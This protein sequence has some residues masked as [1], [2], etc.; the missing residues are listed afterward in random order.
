MT[1]QSHNVMTCESRCHVIGLFCVDCFIF[2]SSCTLCVALLGFVSSLACCVIVIIFIGY[3]AGLSLHL[4]WTTILVTWLPAYCLFVY[5]D[6][7]GNHFK[8][9]CLM[10]LIAVTFMKHQF[11]TFIVFV[12]Y[13]HARLPVAL[14]CDMLVTSGTWPD[15]QV[16]LP[17]SMFMCNGTQSLEIR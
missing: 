17:D 3:F 14:F 10:T 7:C 4:A 13:W 16:C 12:L 8:H 2:T 9:L 6:S 1:C 11:S 5:R 15:A